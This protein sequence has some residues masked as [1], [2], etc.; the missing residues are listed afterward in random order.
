MKCSE[1]HKDLIF[2]IEGD[3]SPERENA[4]LKHL[5]SCS[6]CRAYEKMMRQSLGVIKTEKDV[7]ADDEFEGKVLEKMGSVRIKTYS[8][9]PLLKYAAAAA[10]VVLGVFTGMSIANLTTNTSN[11]KLAEAGEE[12]YYL[13]EVEPIESFFLITYEEDE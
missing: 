1:V 3:L 12:Y 4:L 9:A 11:D 5:D 8:I 7:P 13:D 2:Y 10:V 6:E